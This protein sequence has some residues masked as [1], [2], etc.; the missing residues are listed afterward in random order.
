VIS[1]IMDKA[2]RKLYSIVKEIKGEVREHQQKE[3]L[4]ALA[5]NS[6]NW[7]VEG[8]VKSLNKLIRN[9]YRI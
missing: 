1:A 6:K 8:D 7:L 3:V 2:I 5:K 4:L 9:V